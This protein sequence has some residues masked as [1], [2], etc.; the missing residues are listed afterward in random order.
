MGVPEEK[1]REKGAEI[2]FLKIMAENIPHLGVD[3]DN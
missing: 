1:E 2:L 3:S